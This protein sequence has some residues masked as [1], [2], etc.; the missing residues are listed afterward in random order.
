MAIPSKLD[1]FILGVIQEQSVA[2]NLSVIQSWIEEARV[3]HKTRVGLKVKQWI[4]SPN[5][6]TMRLK[7]Y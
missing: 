3:E 1:T 2:Q 4:R 5:R 6:R 7:G